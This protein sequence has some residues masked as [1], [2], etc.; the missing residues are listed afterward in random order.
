MDR[1]RLIEPLAAAAAALAGLETHEDPAEL[2][3]VILVAWRAVDRSLRLRLRADPRAPEDLRMSALSA[4]LPTTRVI[5]ELRRLD[6]IPLELAGV[7][8]ELQRAARRLVDEPPRAA[9]ADIAR[10]AVQRFRAELEAQRIAADA[11]AAGPA[12]VDAPPPDPATS[13][14]A[15]SAAAPSRR[16]VL[17]AAVALVL[18]AL[19]LLV[20]RGMERP[21]DEAVRAFRENRYEAAEPMFRQILAD[22]PE[23]TTAMLYLARVYRR[24]GR[25]EEAAELLRSAV[26][27]DGRDPDVRRELGHLFLQ[28][29]RPAPAAEQYQLAVELDPEQTMNWIGLIHSL[30]EDGDPRAET[31]LRDAP[32]EVRAALGR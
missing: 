13:A 32:A 22:A 27:V 19:A 23:H 17:G 26:R 7:L 14:V 31:L 30:R 9:D 18:I 28:L 8:S 15:A 2:E 3:R 21:F 10:R 4:D 24:E 5:E 29:G 12:M 1:D 11:P 25:I 20:G 6:A 16:L